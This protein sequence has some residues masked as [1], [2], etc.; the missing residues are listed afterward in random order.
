MDV[1]GAQRRTLQIAELIEHEQRMV[2]GT[3]EVAVVGG[4]FLLAM[5][6]A[7]ARIHIEDDGPRRAPARNGVDPLP[8]ET[9]ERGEVLVTRE[10]FRLEPPHLAGRGRI[11]LDGLAADEPAHCRI[12]P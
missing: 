1:A 8:R 11:A 12:T 5:G 7:D 2:A 9:G 6:R 4:A 3:G 10:P